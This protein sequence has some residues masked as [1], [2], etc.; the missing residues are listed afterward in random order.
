VRWNDYKRSFYEIVSR[1]DLISE[2]RWNPAFFREEFVENDARLKELGAHSLGRFIP[3][4]L[5]DGSKGIT[6]G[7]VG[8]RELSPRGAVRYLQVINI[9]DTGI[10]FAIKP[11]RVAEGS[12]N[13]PKRSRVR[14][15]DIL[16]T[17]NAFRGTDTLLGRCVA[18]PHDYGKMNISQHI[19]RIRV[20]DINPFYVCCFLKTSYG[21]L[22]I[23][24]FMTGVDSSGI[25]FG[26]IKALLI[27][28]IPNALQGEVERQYIEMSA[29]HDRAMAIKERLLEENGIE[30]GQYGE[31]INRLAE[32]SLAY[33]RNVDA[34]KRRLE[35]LL[36][37]L[38][39]VIEGRRKKL[40][41]FPG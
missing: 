19:D 40:R 26:R 17:N 3:D 27:P 31:A 22:Q 37:E 8:A 20:T 10:D 11:D 18:V 34:A 6:Y 24:R 33:R 15:N 13:D 21:S 5:P 12:H 36:A 14:A 41:P 2:N 9:R 28:V 39:A 4:E 1:E 7:Q 35:H 29:H 25:S 23:Q 38:V 16:F 32:E 30:P